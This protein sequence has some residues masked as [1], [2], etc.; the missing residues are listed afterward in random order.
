MKAIRILSRNIRDSFKSVFR[1]FSLSLA[2]ISC[3]TITLIVVAI[4]IV[5]SINVNRFT[6]LVEK[7]VTIVAFLD[8]DVN[9]NDKQTIL[10]EI[11][12][13]TN[14]EKVEFIS[15]TEIANEMMESS[16][17][18]K[19]IMSEWSEGE[20]PIQDTFQVKVKDIKEIKN[21]ANK[22]EKIEKVDLVKYG[23]GM[24]EQLVS[25]FDIIRKVS[26]AAVIALIVVTAFL[27]VN[28][29]KITI[30]SRK[31]EIEIMRLVGASNINI[32][33]P[34]IIEGL[35]LGILGSIIPIITTCY[36]YTALYDKFGGQLF[37]E[38]IKLIEPTP[39]IY[40]VSLILVVIG[41]V[42]GMFGSLRAVKKYLKI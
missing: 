14:V 3:I 16:E 38:F 2:S 13:L 6:E 30:F 5:L 23:E 21:T 34:F 11:K 24:V 39:F 17:E 40:Y 7:D 36:G 18:F 20:S 42:V 8:L 29:I 4:S 28:T 10:E 9:D 19:N 22:I 41:M 25:T 32:K 27:I 37:A 31:R 35:I 12:D 1:N 15:K 33:I 26:V